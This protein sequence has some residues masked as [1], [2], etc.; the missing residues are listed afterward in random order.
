V[1][2]HQENFEDLHFDMKDVSTSMSYCVL[3]CCG[4]FLSLD[5]K[6]PSSASATIKPLAKTLVSSLVE[7]T[8]CDTGKVQAAKIFGFNWVQK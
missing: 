6:G 7:T 4:C 3:L 8:H 2:Q 1:C 5:F